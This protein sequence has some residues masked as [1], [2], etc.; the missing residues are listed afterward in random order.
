MGTASDASL[1]TLG[2]PRAT[3][4]MEGTRAFRNWVQQAGV[5]RYSAEL[6]PHY[7]A[8]EVERLTSMLR[9]RVSILPDIEMVLYLTLLLG[10]WVMADCLHGVLQQRARIAI[11]FGQRFPPDL[12]HAL[13]TN[14]SYDL[15]TGAGVRP[16]S[17]QSPRPAAPMV[18]AHAACGVPTRMSAR[19]P[20]AATSLRPTSSASV[21]AGRR[22]CSSG[23]A[24][25][26]L[27]PLLRD[28]RTIPIWPLT[29]PARLSERERGC[30]ER[31]SPV[32]SSHSSD[33]SSSSAD[34]TPRRPTRRR[35]DF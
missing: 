34:S 14:R 2:M 12:A 8:P 16:S 5:A 3:P 10:P 1:G 6:A 11:R 31:Y 25:S 21:G 35:C 33:A 26:S 4:G 32:W 15:G 19:P 22:P 13:P 18:S 23:L 29:A 17:A 28:P 24:G 7:P 9:T 30:T 20:M 27:A